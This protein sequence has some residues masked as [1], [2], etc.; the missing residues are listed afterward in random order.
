MTCYN[1]DDSNCA[2]PHL[3]NS[4]GN[5][6]RN[7]W[8]VQVARKE[9][10]MTALEKYHVYHSMKTCVYVSESCTNAENPIYDINVAI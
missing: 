10:Y 6:D 9:S 5:I 4:Y 2:S 7:T 3:G 8:I 1:K